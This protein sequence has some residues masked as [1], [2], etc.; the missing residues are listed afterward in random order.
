[1][2]KWTFNTAKHLFGRWQRKNGP[3]HWA[4]DY[5]V[6]WSLNLHF[7]LITGLSP[8]AS[9]SDINGQQKQ[10]IKNVVQ[11]HIVLTDKES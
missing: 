9:V 5:Q 4:I 1:M 10:I 2:N 11:R 7:A 6:K 3:V 8:Q